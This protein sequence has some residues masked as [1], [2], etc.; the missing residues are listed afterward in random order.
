MF[1]AH[2]KTLELQVIV[3]LQEP[4]EMGHNMKDLIPQLRAIPEYQAAAKRIFNRDFDAYVLTR[5]LAA[6]ER[7]LISMSAPLTITKRK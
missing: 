3:P 5:S 1:D 2:L 4:N 7:S 6:F